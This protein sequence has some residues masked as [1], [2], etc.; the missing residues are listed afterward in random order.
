MG[1]QDGCISALLWAVRAEGPAAWA[2]P[3]SQP[4]AVSPEPPLPFPGPCFL[5]GAWVGTVGTYRSE[6]RD[7]ETQNLASLVLVL[8]FARASGSRGRWLKLQMRGPHSPQG[9][10]FRVGVPHGNLLFNQCCAPKGCQGLTEHSADSGPGCRGGVSG[11]CHELTPLT[12][13]GWRSGL[14]RSRP[15]GTVYGISNHRDFFS[16]HGSK[17]AC[18]LH[19]RLPG[20]QGTVEGSFLWHSHPPGN[21]AEPCPWRSALL[22][23]LG[24]TCFYARCCRGWMSWGSCCLAV[25]RVAVGHWAAEV[26]GSVLSCPWSLAGAWHPTQLQKD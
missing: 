3:C 16:G 14:F 18:S 11:C 1:G 23:C 26:W 2:S 8:R 13:W 22:S 21:P 10:W 12:P 4:P 9:L 7:M 17:P 20:R 25:C 15:C 6:D 24:C 19:S 5:V